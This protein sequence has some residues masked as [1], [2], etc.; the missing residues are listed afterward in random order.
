MKFKTTFFITFLIF[1]VLFALS[2]GKLI[3]IDDFNLAPHN[4]EYAIPLADSK[5]SLQTI[6][7]GL[8]NSAF[9]Q[10]GADGGLTL[11]YEGNFIGRSTLDILAGYQNALLP[12]LDTVFALP[13]NIPNGVQIDFANLKS[14]LLTYYFQSG[15]T[16]TLSVKLTI[17]QLLKN[18]AAF[19]TTFSLAPN[20]L[21][22]DSLD[23]GGY[24]LQPYKDSIFVKYDARRPDGTR[25]S[26]KKN[27][28]ALCGALI[29]LKNFQLQ[30]AQGY[31]GNNTFD[32]PQDTIRINF[33]QNWKG[34]IRF[35]DPRLTLA[36]ENSF[37]VPVRATENYANAI[38]ADGK[39]T[40][41]I[42]PAL[43]K[44]VDVAYPAL[45]EV[46][47]SKTTTFVLNAA[48]SNLPDVLASNPVAIAYKIDAVMNPNG[49]T[50]TTGFLTDS[51]A[52]KLHAY[53]DL[54]VYGKAQGFEGADTVAI[55]FSQYK[56]NVDHVE[57][58]IIADNAM[59]VDIAVQG[60]FAN[61][62]GKILDSLYVSPQLVL[63]SAAVDANGNATTPTR[64]ISYTTIDYARFQRVADAAKLWIH[65]YYSTALNGSVPV[66]VL[67]TQEVRVQIGMKLGLR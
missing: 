7:A 44:G 2:C 18:G 53:L 45:S 43:Q 29:S 67:A 52:F 64:Q 3:P 37:G 48:N 14:G 23:V 19:Q 50:K 31:L 30:Y 54:P 61:G 60:Y 20:S 24:R 11:H 1:T 46:G 47:Q 65:Y 51:S 57:L 15:E 6:L 16:Q 9:I 21:K 33:F 22:T 55:D 25:V 36:L 28:C 56:K 13:F 63:K 59:P 58:K 40:P 12:V 66:R 41:I 8:D 49:S 26:L 39:A 5:T 34:N 27:G 32:I 10:I 35:Q 4:A 42:S 62:Q 17:P 38:S